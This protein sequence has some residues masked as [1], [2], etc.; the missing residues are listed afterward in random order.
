M[1]PVRRPPLA[2]VAVSLLAALVVLLPYTLPDATTPTIG[3]YYGY[4]LLGGWSVLIVA[5][6]S[7]V[8]FASGSQRR[9]DPDVVAGAVLVLSLFALGLAAYWALA[10]PYGVVVEITPRDWFAYHRW[11]LVGLTV[12]MVVVSAWYAYVLDLP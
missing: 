6:V 2:G 4:G 10:V 12:V 3:T 7:V 8:V 9:T 1:D 11:A 5:L